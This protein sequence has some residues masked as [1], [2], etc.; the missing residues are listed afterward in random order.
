MSVDSAAGGRTELETVVFH[1]LEC[2]SYDADI[3]LW[4]EL[5]DRAGGPVL[6]I[7]AGLGRVSRVL[8]AAGHEVVALDT[9]AVLLARL[10]AECETV[11]TVV[12]DARDFSLDRR[13]AL[14]IAPMQTLQLLGGV[15]G[16]AGFFARVRTHLLPAGV[17]A[18]AIVADVP[19]FAPFDGGLLPAAD[20][21]ERDGVVYVSQALALRVL[22]QVYELSRAR[23]VL[24]PGAPVREY[25]DVVELDRVGPEA[26]LGEGER[27]GLRGLTHRKIAATDEH[28]AS[29][30]VMWRG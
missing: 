22:P 24:A 18:C 9:D 26:L 19:A 1:A 15:R 25:D 17:L 11:E 16:R 30:V 28:V 23:S 27:A 12:A 7:G 21:E 13:F 4:L 2:G 3:A 5:A 10:A 20:I 14:V 8:V 29:A 6:E